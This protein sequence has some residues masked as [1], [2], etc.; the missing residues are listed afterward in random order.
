MSGTTTVKWVLL[1]T[2]TPAIQVQCLVGPNIFSPILLQ[3]LQHQH[4]RQRG[5]FFSFFKVF[6]EPKFFVLFSSLSSG[7]G[8]SSLVRAPDSWLKGSL[9]ESL[10]EQRENFLLQG[11][12]SVLIYFGIRST[13]MLSLSH[14]K[15]PG[16]SAKSAGGR[17]WLNMH[18]PYVHGFARSDMEHGCMV[19]TELAPRRQQFHVAPAMP[20]LK[21][22]TS[23]D[24]PKHAMKGLQNHMWAQW[25]CSR[26]QRIALYKWSSINQSSSLHLSC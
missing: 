24:I 8:D 26:E 3:L 2:L 23:V 1:W 7:G 11:R 22:T 5:I 20:A 10:Q 15:D 18:T 12:L 6:V 19:Y 14:V 16:H 21:Y 17:L 4:H 25:V 13:P 9:F